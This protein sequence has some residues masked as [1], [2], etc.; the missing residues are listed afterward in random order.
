MWWLLYGV[1]VLIVTVGVHCCQVCCYESWVVLLK[2]F[3][4]GVVSI[5]DVVVGVVSCCVVRGENAIDVD[6]VEEREGKPVVLKCRV[7]VG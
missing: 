6:G 2:L 4:G 3:Q 7:I 5:R 1:V